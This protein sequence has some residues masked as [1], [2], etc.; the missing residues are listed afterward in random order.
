MRHARSTIDPDW[1]ASCRLLHIVQTAESMHFQVAV[2]YALSSGV[3]EA[4]DYNNKL[5]H[6][7]WM[8]LQHL[9]LPKMIL[10]DFNGQLTWPT[11]APLVDAGYVALD[12]LYQR[13]YGDDIPKICR[14]AT[15]PDTAICC[16]C[17]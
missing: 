17:I 3:P 10:S 13:L 9:P 11:A 1:I 8:A 2:V 4:A 6:Q 15:Q 12:Q 14:N 5:L 7:A 16:P